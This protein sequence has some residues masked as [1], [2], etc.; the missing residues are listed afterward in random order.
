MIAVDEPSA[1]R[2]EEQGIVINDA[3]DEAGL[4]TLESTLRSY[5]LNYRKFESTVTIGPAKWSAK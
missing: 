4:T 1:R 3:L 2:I 5:K